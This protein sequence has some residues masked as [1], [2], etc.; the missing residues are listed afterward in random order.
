MAKSKTD[1]AAAG[2]A[3]GAPATEQAAPTTDDGAIAAA[4]VARDIVEKQMADLSPAERA[5]A[6]ARL[7]RQAAGV[8]P[9]K[10]TPEQQLD[11][12]VNIRD[13][14]AEM[15]VAQGQELI[16]C[17]ARWRDPSNPDRILAESSL[18]TGEIQSFYGLPWRVGEYK[19]NERGVIIGGSAPLTGYVPANL[20]DETRFEAVED[21]GRA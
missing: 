7:A 8:L 14:V 21:D 12:G 19:T 6:L 10:W 1:S 20:W 9:P 11:K 4:A 16:K 17:R 5:A 2:T 18:P 13:V 3:E 15:A